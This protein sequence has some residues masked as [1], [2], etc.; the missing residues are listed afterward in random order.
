MASGIC[1]YLKWTA[2]L[3]FQMGWAPTA[4]TIDDIVTT[5]SL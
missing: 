3:L 2:I 5:L 4:F 1:K